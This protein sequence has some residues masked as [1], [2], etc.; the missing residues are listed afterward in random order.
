MLS[1]VIPT[2]RDTNCAILE[3]TLSSLSKFG[4]VEIICVDRKEA[5]SRAERLNIGFHRAKGEVILF[6]HPRS[7]VDPDG[8]QFLI[9][10]SLDPNRNQFWGGFTHQFDVSHP[11][12]KFTSWYSNK[13]RVMTRGILYLDHCIFFDRRLW[14]KNLPNV[15]IFE[16]TLLCYEFRKSIRPLLLKYSS[17]TSSIRFQKNGLLKQAILNQALKVGFHLNVS[18]GLMNRLYER[19]LGLNSEYTKKN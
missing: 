18:H 5:H 7:F 11:F 16:D 19:G 3:K 17:T 14:K 4:N 2:D 15:D 1:V 9:N 8:I 6:N 13:I 10:K 12:L